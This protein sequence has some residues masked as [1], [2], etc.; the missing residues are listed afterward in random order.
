MSFG[1]P[2]PAGKRWFDY[3]GTIAGLVLLVLALSALHHIVRGFHWVSFVNQASALHAWQFAAALLFTSISYTTLTTYDIMAFRYIRHPIEYRKIAFASFIGYAFSNNVGLSMLSGGSVRYRLY[4]AW[5]LSAVEITKVVAFCSY[6]FA[7]G[8]VAITGVVFSFDPLP[9]HVLGLTPLAIRVLGAMLLVAL[10]AYLATNAVRRGPLR[11]AGWQFR[12][13]GLQ[14]SLMQ[15]FVCAFDLTMTGTVVYM[16]LPTGVHIPYLGFIGIFLVSNVLGH[17]S[18]VPGGL[19]VF[20]TT[21]IFLLSDHLPVNAVLGTLLLFRSIYH[22]LPLLLG[23][24]LLTGHEARARRTRL[25]AA[26]RSAEGWSPSLMPQLL[27]LMAFIGGAVLLFSGAVPPV[28]SRFI[29]LRSVVGLPVIEVAH[30]LGS[31]L[32]MVLVMISFSLERRL[33]QAYRFTVWLLSIGVVLTLLRGLH[34]EEALVL[35][36]ILATFAISGS[37]FH[38]TSSVLSGRV[39]AEQVAMVIIAVFAFLFLGLFSFREVTYSNYLWVR[40]SAF[41]DASRFLRALLGIGIAAAVLSI[42]RWRRVREPIPAAPTRQELLALA[43]IINASPRALTL[44]AL[45]GDKRILRGPNESFVMFALGKGT[46]VALGDPVTESM[47]DR[48]EMVWAFRQMCDDN[49]VQPVFYE[50][51]QSNLQL[52]LDV[53]LTILALGEEAVVETAGVSLQKSSLY[54]LLTARRKLEERGV[55]IR[56]HPAPA[57]VPLAELMRLRDDAAW[58]GAGRGFA[59]GQLTDDYLTRA[60][61]ITARTSE[62]MVGYI[63]VL[64]SADHSD[65]VVDL[66]RIDPAYDHVLV[67]SLMLEALLLERERGVPHCSLGM[68][69]L[70]GMSVRSFGPIWA[71]IGSVLYGHGEQVYGLRGQRQDKEPFEPQWKPKYLASPG[72]FQLPRILTDIARLIRHSEPPVA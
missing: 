43:P 12:L 21:M 70:P 38:R 29:M 33:A 17:L 46:A 32:G 69:P 40:F 5:G 1:S 62:G 42:A 58:H 51:D 23:M 10:A 9:I 54:E 39:K 22:V 20:E 19:G 47:A 3:I 50:V 48:A 59:F 61:V 57:D 49:D 37:Y 35:S 25:H 63:T 8:T 11:I 65:A 53:G 64:E 45:S 41:G 36:L 27:S 6:T 30:F 71:R 4:S 7:L 44:L 72:G 26:V 15:I 68:A 52:Y 16:L 2:V 60:S 28:Q 14:M 67:R 56:R 31:A 24:I 18:Q 66:L 34:Y 55:V 13:P